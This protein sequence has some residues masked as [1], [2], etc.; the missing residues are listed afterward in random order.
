MEH[1]GG[2]HNIN[3]TKL[4]ELAL[5]DGFDPRTQKQ[6][7][8]H[9]GDVR[10]FKTF[11]DVKEAYYKQLE[12]FVPVLHKI[13]MLSL[14]TEITDGPMSGLRC[15]MQYEDC[16]RE[17]LTPKEG[18][19]RY[20]EGRTSWLG[21]RGMVD[22]ADSLSAVKKL[23]FDEK[24]VTMSEMMDALAKNWEGSEELRQMCLN[25]PKYG[26][27]DDYVDEIYDELSTKVP[28]IM[29]RWLAPITG[30]QPMLVIGA[31]AGHIAIGL[32]VGALPNGR[33]AGSP[34]ATPPARSCPAATSTARRRPST[35]PRTAR[36]R[37]RSSATP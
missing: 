37:K 3:Q 31:A 25:A 14:C 20:P 13:K 5:N 28:E 24:K 33:L 26:N 34:T 19:A 30:K 11:E 22:I 36:T 2:G 27:D 7:G 18:G 8:P 15:A 35:P 17:G 1:L 16:I 9:T 32:R 10:T 23:V 29:Q 12:Y 6:L 21:S 4:L